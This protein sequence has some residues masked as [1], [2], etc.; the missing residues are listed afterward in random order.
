MPAFTKGEERNKL[1]ILVLNQAL[2]IELTSE[3]I[4]RAVFEGNYMSYFDYQNA[5]YELEEDG[6]IAAIPRQI[7]QVY[8]ITPAGKEALA[9]LIDTVPAGV[10]NDISAY[11]EKNR[12]D[13]LEET[14]FPNSMEELSDGT[15]M[16]RIAVTDGSKTEM[17]VEMHVQTREIAQNMRSNWRKNAYG[18]FSNLFGALSAKEEGSSSAES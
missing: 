13:L 9:S 3:Q 1:I 6:W 17:K 12:D 18:I 16:V 14:R 7:G 10:R 2:D 11:A 4:H 15:Y 8:R 5:M